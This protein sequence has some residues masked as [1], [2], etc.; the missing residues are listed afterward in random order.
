MI[1]SMEHWNG[2][3]VC[4]ID[5]ET[6]GLDDRWNEMWQICVLPLDSNFRPRANITPFYTELKPEHPERIDWNV[7]VMRHN[8][9]KIL[10]ACERGLDPM[11]AA[12]L[13]VEWT[14]KLKLPLTRT[15]L[16]KKITPLGQNFGFDRG[17]IK[18]WLTW[19]VY[20]EVFDYH[21]NDTMIVAN[22]LNNVAGMKAERVPFTRVGLSNLARAFDVQFA[23]HDA[24][25]DCVATAAVYRKMLAQGLLA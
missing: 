15:G 11:K 8:R 6:T 23:H 4:V 25:E 12:D 1:E 7:T 24:L 18:T 13:F 20:D 22:F 9:A 19:G 21:Y 2:N 3:Q 14:N 17:F 5:T 10:K 16:R